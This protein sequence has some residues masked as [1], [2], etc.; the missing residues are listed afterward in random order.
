M[1]E[2]KQRNFYWMMIVFVAVI[3]VVFPFLR[4]NSNVNRVNER[5]RKGV[6]KEGD[7]KANF[8]K[9]GLD[10]AGGVDLLYQ[11][12]PA[13]G[14]KTQTITKSEMEG[15]IETIRRRVDPEGVKEVSV[16]Q[17]GIDRLNVQIPGESD[18][19]RTKKLTCPVTALP[20]PA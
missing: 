7:E 13:P 19:E 16:Q 9:L 15:L 3:C 2:A 6:I 11:A 8:I 10:L 4:Y 1:K 20:A 18:P 14:S 5:V 12:E 17:I